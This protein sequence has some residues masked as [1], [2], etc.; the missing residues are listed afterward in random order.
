MVGTTVVRL[1]KV[2]VGTATVVRLDVVHSVVETPTSLEV[3]M[4]ITTLVGEVYSLEEVG[5]T[6]L[7]EVTYSLLEVTALAAVESV[8]SLVLVVTTTVVDE[9]QS[10]SVALTWWRTG[11]LFS[12]LQGL[13]VSNA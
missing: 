5:T 4:G 7:L 9:V 8:H 11:A 10:L 6:T 13:R 12:S 3:L 1:V 2:L